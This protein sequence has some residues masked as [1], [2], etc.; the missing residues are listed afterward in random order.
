MLW[1]ALKLLRPQLA[2]AGLTICLL[3]ALVA[4]LGVAA[5]YKQNVSMMWAYSIF[6]FF[7][8][9][10][11]LCI[12]LD[13]LDILH[14]L[15]KPPA[16]PTTKADSE[17]LVKMVE[18]E[19]QDAERKLGV[20]KTPATIANPEVIP[21]SKLTG[22]AERSDHV[23][24]APAPLSSRQR[25]HRHKRKIGAVA[26][27][28]APLDAFHQAVNTPSHVRHTH[29]GFIDDDLK[30]EGVRPHFVAVGDRLGA[31]PEEVRTMTSPITQSD[32]VGATGAASGP[33]QAA[34]GVTAS[35]ET[36][37]KTGKETGKETGKLVVKKV[38]EEESSG[39]AQEVSL[40]EMPPGFSTLTAPLQTLMEGVMKSEKHMVKYAMGPLL[41]SFAGC[42]LYAFY[43]AA[44]FAYNRCISFDVLEDSPDQFEPLILAGD[45]GSNDLD[46]ANLQLHDDSLDLVGQAPTSRQS[47]RSSRPISA[48]TNN[49]HTHTQPHNSP[50]GNARSDIPAS[51]T[52][53]LSPLNNARAL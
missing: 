16:R 13:F 1:L 50:F 19:V 30:S 18:K 53:P 43:A 8:F 29:A 41:L 52:S 42:G 23:L 21:V 2:A 40:D 6:L 20:A 9:V 44:S 22:I 37:E 49:T 10:M 34:D 51:Q 4:C 15:P 14:V 7:V 38:K 39:E 33:V 32:A 27:H 31:A 45:G 24:L 48:Q 11:N 5:A 35:T 47:S 26:R 36:G 25:M 46:L 12:G 3:F 28:D 17:G